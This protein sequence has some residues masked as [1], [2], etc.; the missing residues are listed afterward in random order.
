MSTSLD[1]WKNRHVPWTRALLFCLLIWGSFIVYSSQQYAMAAD[2]SQDWLVQDASPIA[3]GP[4][5]QSIP[6]AEGDIVIYR[7]G[8]DL[9]GINLAGNAGSQLL[10]NNLSDRLN[11]LDIKSKRAIYQKI[12]TGRKFCSQDLSVEPWSQAPLNCVTT[13]TG[14]NI[15]ANPDGMGVFYDGSYGS[16]GSGGIYYVDF[17]AGTYS[18]FSSYIYTSHPYVTALGPIWTKWQSWQGS[19]RS[20][21]I[22]LLG[23]VDKSGPGCEMNTNR[24]IARAGGGFIIYNRKIGTG[25]WDL[26]AYL[27]EPDSDDADIR[28]AEGVVAGGVGDQRDAEVASYSDAQGQVHDLIVWEDSRNGNFDIYMKD[29]ATSREY[30]ICLGAGDQKEPAITIDSEG[31]PFIVWQDDRN[32]NLDIY[33]TK[34]VMA[35]TLAEKHRP[36][37]RMTMGENF[38]PM[39][40]EQFLTEPDSTLRQRNNPEFS[41][42]KPAAATLAQYANTPDLYIDLQGDSIAAGGGNPSRSINHE[43]VHDNYAVPYQSRRDQVGSQFPRTIYARV[44]S[45]PGGNENSFIQ[46]WL[47]YAA[48]DH[49]EIFHEGDWEVVQI[50]LDGNLK[51]YRANY[52][53]HGYGQWRNWEGPGSVEKSEALPD[54]PVVYVGVG[55]HANYFTANAEHSIYGQGI[56]LSYFKVWDDAS[57]SG[58]VLNNSDDNNA[59]TTQVKLIPE[60]DQVDIGSG[61]EWLNFMGQWGEFTNAVVEVPLHEDLPGLRDGSANPPLQAYWTNA[62]AWNDNTCDG[63]QDERAQGTDTQCTALSPVDISLYDAQGRHTGKNADGSI[64]QQIPNSEYLEYPDLHRKSIIIHGSDINQGYRFEATGNGTGP[65]SFIVTA[66]DHS[67]GYVDTLNYNTVEVNPSTKVT[68]T[69]DSDKNYTMSIDPDGDG[70]NAIQKSPD[71]TTTNIV[72]F[73]PPAQISD[74]GVTATSAG[75]A[76]LTF[77]APGDDGNAGTATAYDLRYSTAAITDQYWK[78]AIPV[79]GLPTP[80]QAGSSQ[81]ITV[82]GLSPGTTYNFALKTM[83]ESALYSPLSNVAIGTTTIPSLSWSKLRTYWAN[84]T[85]YQNRQLSIDYR[86]S[87]TGTGFALESTVQASFCNP[88]TVYSV[89]QLPSAVGDINPGSSRTVTLKYFVPTNVGSFTTTTYATCNDDAGSTYWFP[90]SM[91]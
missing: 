34:A 31:Q 47:F 44:V 14:Y 38:E 37:L 70:A 17:N 55:S 28:C 43:Q 82:I 77:I 4:A 79:S 19:Y 87:N 6:A 41:I 88:S 66:P 40:V 53:Q 69:L 50:D 42:L 10:A 11:N 32:G 8:T 46:Y 59:I 58:D 51:P 22:T 84:W 83:D 52:S 23:L 7:S 71:T 15:S 75:S 65:A 45:R 86:M 9:Y 60:V 25:D 12:D 78:D 18:N 29:L 5:E 56:D 63:C 1:Y 68:M 36:E 72:D 74:L 2:P 67:G 85:D 39:P 49:A 81:S 13:T 73:T 3:T 35:K 89:T 27:G 91:P 76:T 30:P 62:F 24:D 54:Q 16:S 48:N 26:V 57:G 20:N 61:F 21:V 33:G 90:G 64:D 80:L